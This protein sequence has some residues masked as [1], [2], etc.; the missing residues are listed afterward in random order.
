ML[1]YIHSFLLSNKS[2]R[3]RVKSPIEFKLGAYVT[4][5]VVSSIVF[6]GSTLAKTV[7]STEVVEE[8]GT[9]TLSS[10]LIDAMHE[11]ISTNTFDLNEPYTLI[12]KKHFC[13]GVGKSNKGTES[14]FEAFNRVPN[15]DPA[16]KEGDKK[17][18]KQTRAD[19]TREWTYTYLN[20][21]W[22]LT[23]YKYTPLPDAD[24]LEP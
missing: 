1:K 9:P 23:G 16:P 8:K 11:A 22:V 19:G 7:C 14:A 10:E 21:V 13:T 17:T 20:G 5:F 24:S 18:V 6:S 12:S 2:H 15:P 4:F 3:V